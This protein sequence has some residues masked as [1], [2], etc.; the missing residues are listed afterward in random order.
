MT[1]G[2]IKRRPSKG[3]GQPGTWRKGLQFERLPEGL[4]PEYAKDTAAPW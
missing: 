2:L 1:S 4:G 3:V